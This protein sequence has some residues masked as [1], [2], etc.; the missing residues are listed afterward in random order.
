MNAP[1]FASGSGGRSSRLPVTSPSRQVSL[2]YSRREL[3]PFEPEV[4]AHD[5][6]HS[7]F[8]EQF[9]KYLDLALKHRWL[10][11]GVCAGALAIGLAVTYTSTPMY[12]ASATIQIDQNAPKVVKVDAAADAPADTGDDTRFY[13]TQYDL[14]KSA[15]LA[16]RV[17]AD[18]DLANNP[19]FLHPKSSSPWAMLWQTLFP[20]RAADGGNVEQRKA[21]AVAM[22]QNGVTVAPLPN[23]R[24]VRI[25]YQSSDP[26]WASKITNGIAESFISANLDRRFGASAYARTFLKERLDELKLKL[27][28]SEKALVAYAEKE[29]IMTGKGQPSLAD[30]DLNS[31]YG[32]LQKVRTQRIQAEELWDQANKSKGLALSQILN[33]ASIQKLRGKR[34]ELM[35]EYQEKLNLFKP[36]YPD[37][38]KIKAQIDQID[39]EIELNASAIKQSMKTSYQSLLQQESLLQKNIDDAKAKVLDAR[40][41]NIQY[42]ILQRESDTTRSLYDGLLQQYKDIGVAGAVGTNNVAIIDRASRPSVPFSPSL[43]KNLLISLIL[44][45]LAAAAAV[46]V[47]EIIDD[48]FKSPEEI[49]E[50][51]GLPVLGI[52]PKTEGIF[53]R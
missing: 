6:A 40:N 35:S 23:S 11:G 14:L 2:E 29:Q 50:Q 39:R 33:D 21:A 1:N 3:L 5:E 7:D 51:L 10:I 46:A 17:A 25:S 49:E 43:S 26:E 45:L 34:A 41:K 36:D 48:S 15:S 53:F 27:E 20:A 4:P 9:F 30:T 8:R 16:Q 28:E 38:R 52:I 37:M 47:L 42:Q 24:I 18:L 19:D 44:G 22:V 12:R 32:E 13:Q 31:L